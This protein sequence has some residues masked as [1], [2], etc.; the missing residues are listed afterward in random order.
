MLLRILKSLF[1]DRTQEI[2]EGNCISFYHFLLDTL[3]DEIIDIPPEEDGDISFCF[4]IIELLSN[5]DILGFEL[6]HW[7]EENTK[8]YLRDFAGL[9]KDEYRSSIAKFKKIYIFIKK[10]YFLNLS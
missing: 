2:D 3:E 7:N 5:F 4:S 1:D 10:D 8:E 9:S 6:S